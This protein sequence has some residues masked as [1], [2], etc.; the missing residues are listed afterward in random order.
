MNQ[1]IVI[2]GSGNVATHLGKTLCEKKHS[3]VQIYSK[4]LSNAKALAEKLHADFT[5][6]IE[7]VNR[8]A[9]SYVIAVTDNAVEEVAHKI[10][11][12][13]KLIVHTSGS[14]TMDIL[15]NCSEN[16]GVFY[17][18]QT[19]T[20]EKQVVF[21]EIPICIEANSKKNE[22]TLS[23]LAQSLSNS[24]HFINSEQRKIIHL[25]AVFACNFTNHL[26][27]VAEEILSENE[28]PFEILK[29]LIAETTEKIKENSPKKT[30]TGPAIRKDEKVLKKHLE[31]LNNK[32][33]WQELYSLISKGIQL[34]SYS[35]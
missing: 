9:D 34:N 28:I 7:N 5:D 17:P 4:T 14:I 32:P 2:I 24:V 25:A 1:K 11:V 16:Y 29:P 10:N 26:Y 13:D 33:E 8:D 19:F 21:S 31:M 6:Q 15:K 30:Q 12:N 22:Q 3:I 27:G 23:E 18:L 35:Q 20:K